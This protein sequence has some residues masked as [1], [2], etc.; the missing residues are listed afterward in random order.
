MNLPL[1]SIIVP[2]YNT[3]NYLRQC[4]DS[5]IFQTLQN[6]EIIII[7]DGSTDNSPA[8]CDSYSYDKRIIVRHEKNQGVSKTR[9]LGISLSSGN[10]IMF[11]DSDDWIDLKT[12]EK[13]A[14]AINIENPDLIISGNMNVAS[15][16]QTIRHLFKGNQF[17]NL[18]NYQNNI[19]IPTMGLVGSQLKNPAKL[20]K[21]TPV[22]ARLYKAEIIKK[23]SIKYIDLNVLPSECLQFNFE[24]CLHASSAYYVDEPL[25]Y[26]RRNTQFSVTKPYRSNLIEKWDW[27]YSYTS[28]YIL[29]HCDST[30]IWDAFYSRICCSVIPLG[31]NALK[32]KNLKDIVNEVHIFLNNKNFIKAF[33]KFDYSNCPIYWKLYFYAAK[34]QRV[35]LFVFLTWCMRKILNLRKK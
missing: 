12:C 6:I 34:K 11:V 23:H 4:L 14:A 25:Y 24:F 27:W 17:F 30:I 9:N 16:G 28:S 32:L 2:V 15:S 3:Q 8:I 33:S 7:D 1:I 35:L 26:Y 21:L 18:E 31:G 5:L 13:M 10:Y 29:S 19:L 22:W 20:D